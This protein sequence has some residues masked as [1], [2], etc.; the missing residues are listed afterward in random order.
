[1]LRARITTFGILIITMI[2][3]CRQDSEKQQST[4]SDTTLTNVDSIAFAFNPDDEFLGLGVPQFGDLDS[5]IA[6]KTI[7]ALV[8]YTYLYYYIDGKERRGIAFEALNIF[9]K[10]L[11]QQLGF[12]PPKVRVLFIPV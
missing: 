7:R 8:P 12:Y 9:E 10:S 6:R 2:V 4:I 11:N 3:S 5:M 1:M